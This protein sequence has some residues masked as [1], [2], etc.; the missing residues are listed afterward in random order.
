MMQRD[1]LF[2]HPR[3]QDQWLEITDKYIWVHLKRE[4]SND[5]SCPQSEKGSLSEKGCSLLRSWLS[6]SEVE[7]APWVVMLVRCCLW[8][9]LGKW[10]Y[11]LP[12]IKCQG[13]YWESLS[14]STLS[15]PVPQFQAGSPQS[16]LRQVVWICGC[17]GMGLGNE[18]SGAISVSTLGCKWQ[19][20]NWNC[21]KQN[22]KCISPKSG[23]PKWM[24]LG[25]AG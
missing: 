13:E 19:K 2:C 8:S 18:G 24:E 11:A 4:L 1:K 22:K 23:K 5:W 21:I 14:S 20:A 12:I 7:R 16:H 25:A 15:L 6:A 10:F 9:H 17:D 3:K